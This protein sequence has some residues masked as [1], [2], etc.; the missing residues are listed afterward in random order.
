M[1]GRVI[2]LEGCLKELRKFPLDL[3]KD[4]ITLVE[5]LNNNVKFGMPLSRLMP[6]IGKGVHELRLKETHVV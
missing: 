5:Q 1:N 2:I 3:Q 4:L 6:S